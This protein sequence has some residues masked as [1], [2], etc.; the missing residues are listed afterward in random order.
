MMP[1]IFRQT[2]MLYDNTFIFVTMDSKHNVQNVGCLCK[3]HEIAKAR[4]LFLDAI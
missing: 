2:T 1:S 3:V 4:E